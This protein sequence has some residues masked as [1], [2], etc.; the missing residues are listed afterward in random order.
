MNDNSSCVKLPTTAGSFSKDEP[1][2]LDDILNLWDGIRETPGR[3][4]VISSNHYDKLDDALIRPGRIDISHELSNS[5]HDTIAKLYSH[6]YG[7]EINKTMLKKIKPY[8]YSPAEIVNL[9]IGN[10]D[11]EQAFLK[12]LIQNKKVINKK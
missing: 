9:Y 4:I 11:D 1:I 7:S 3:I 12:R 6:L 5:S 8:F 10:K 2:T